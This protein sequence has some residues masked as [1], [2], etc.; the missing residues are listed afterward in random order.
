MKKST[1]SAPPVSI[2]LWVVCGLAISAVSV[3]TLGAWFSIEGLGKLF[4]GAVVSVWIMAGALEIAKFTIAAFLHQVWPR[5][6]FL[7]KSYLLGSV[8]M[9]SGI[10]SLGIFGFLSDAYQESSTILE[11]E[12]IKLET[13]KSNQARLE[14]DIERINKSIEE[15]PDSRI[16]KKM[17]ARAEAEPMILDLRKKQE[18]LQAEVTQASLKVLAVK[19]KVGPLIYIARVFKMDIDL[20]VKYLIF[21]FVLVFDPLALC[22]VVAFS[23]ALKLRKEAALLATDPKTTIRV[24]HEDI[25]DTEYEAPED[26]ATSEDD[27]NI[28]MRFSLDEETP[29]PGHKE[30]KEGGKENNG[31]EAS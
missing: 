29:I 30:I 31:E 6:N 1:L 26:A 12:T 28:K 11:S 18:T 27:E 16:S 14:Q 10:T 23:M 21:A 13:L 15:I 20:V 5:L 25:I 7:F 17:R 3:S 9:L 19:D 24:Q 4:T 8:V 2:Q 22:L